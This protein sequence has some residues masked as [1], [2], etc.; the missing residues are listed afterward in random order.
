MAKSKFPKSEGWI[1]ARL[2][3]T[4]P[5]IWTPEMVREWVKFFGYED[6]E[7]GE[8]EQSGKKLKII[9]RNL[10]LPNPGVGKHAAA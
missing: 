4:K 5:D 2:D 9:F 6:A 3:L 7:I 8:F 10:P 1:T